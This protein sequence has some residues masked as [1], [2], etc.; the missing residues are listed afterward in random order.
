MPKKSIEDK[1]AEAIQ[2]R[3]TQKSV[4]LIGNGLNRISPGSISWDD[5]LKKLIIA[6][7]VDHVE[8]GKKPLT[9]LF[10]EISH[11]MNGGANRPNIKKLKCEVANVISEL[12]PGDFHENF[13]RLNVEDILTTNY[14]YCLEKELDEN[15]SRSVV[16]N[17]DTEK[18]YSINRCNRAK[19][20]YIW[21]IHGELDNGFT[22]NTDEHYPEHSIML[23]FDQ[24]Q[25][26]LE[27]IVKKVKSASFDVLQD[28]W[29]KFLFT[30]NIHIV[31]LDLGVFET[32]LWW[33]LNFRAMLTA[34]QHCIKNKII[35][36]APV[37]ENPAEKEEQFQM[38]SSFDVTVQKIE[39]PHNNG[40]F[41]EGFYD[42]LYKRLER[43]LGVV[44]K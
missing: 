24:Y 6:S 9:F 11:R 15:F 13:L 8:P 4:L 1:F 30:H 25:G 23:G 34:R 43:E 17:K 36:Y 10:E 42:Q 32:H 5:L 28:T 41:Y 31:G 29:I 44:N 14:D 12:K 40:K 3:Y 16:T 35:F 21:H 26:Y 20:K 22:A 18:K 33:L 7:G 38:L 37:H 27:R 2:N 19:D 39:C